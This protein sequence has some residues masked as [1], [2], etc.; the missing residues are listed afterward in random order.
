MTICFICDFPFR[1]FSGG[2]ERVSTL[3]INEFSHLGINVLCCFPSKYR[4]TTDADNIYYLEEEEIVSK[5]NIDFLHNLIVDNN[6]SILI[7]Q[8]TL[9]AIHSL[10]VQAKNQTNAKLI[11]VNHS[12]PE[13]QV[14]DLT[15]KID[16]IS[17][18][19]KNVFKR[20]LLQ[21][22]RKMMYPL[23]Y[24]IRYLTLKKM[25]QKK[26]EDSDCYVLLSEEYVKRVCNIIGVYKNR[27]I[28]SIS[29]PVPLMPKEGK[30]IN[31]I[32]LEKE[33]MVLFVGRMVFQKR[34]D[35]MLRIWKKV[36]KR[37]PDWRLVIIGDG[38][39]LP[40]MKSYAER[41]SLE[42]CYFEGKKDA[43]QVMEKASIL[44]M[45]STHECFPMTLLEAQQF[46]CVP[47]S[48][49][50]YEAVHD[51]IVDKETGVLVPS[52]D[53]KEYSKRLEDLM[54]NDSLRKEMAVKAFH[55]VSKFSSDRIAE[56]WADLFQEL[57]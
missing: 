57:L 32:M 20:F 44:C 18:L 6:V 42:R 15:D 37:V 12:N 25:H 51:I 1:C 29:N 7:N 33:K 9:Q 41:L 23:S 46:G 30:S 52:F 56:Q 8:S 50:S 49:D 13:F 43:L 27:K 53:E 45:Q 2:V 34:V 35:R 10:V 31:Q 17:F 26:Y 36:Q 5:H 19:E 22:K 14:K 40:I 3:L 16:E 4:N 21:I 47:I 54:K 39:M 11:T 24:S 55:S 28:C 38:D 48:F